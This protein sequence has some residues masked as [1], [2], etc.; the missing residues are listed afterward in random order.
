MLSQSQRK[1]L[2][3]ELCLSLQ[4]LRARTDLVRNI[5]PVKVVPRELQSS[6]EELISIL[7]VAD[8]SLAAKTN[9][10][11]L[12]CS[13]IVIKLR[14]KLCNE[15]SFNLED[16]LEIN[17]EIL[18][19]VEYLGQ[20][21]VAI[22]RLLSLKRSREKSFSSSKKFQPD[23]SDTAESAAVIRNT[24]QH[25]KSDVINNDVC[26]SKDMVSTTCKDGSFAQEQQA[27]ILRS[28]VTNQQK[29]IEEDEAVGE[30]D[31]PAKTDE[32]DSSKPQQVVF[33]SSQTSGGSA[34]F[35]PILF[36]PT[37]PSTPIQE[38]TTLMVVQADPPKL[39]QT[40]F[41]PTPPQIYAADTSWATHHSKAVAISSHTQ[42]DK[43]VI[44]SP[45]HTSLV[46]PHAIP[47]EER[48]NSNSLD[49]SDVRSTYKETNSCVDQ[50]YQAH[51][52][53]K[54]S[55]SN[56]VKENEVDPAHFN[57]TEVSKVTHERD[58]E[59]EEDDPVS[60][61]QEGNFGTTVQVTNNHIHNKVDF[62]ETEGVNGDKNLAGKTQ[63]RKSNY[64]TPKKPDVKIC[65]KKKKCTENIDSGRIRP[66]ST[67]LQGPMEGLIREYVAE[68]PC[69]RISEKSKVK[70]SRK[71]RF[72][73]PTENGD[74]EEVCKEAFMKLTGTYSDFI[75]SELKGKRNTMSINVNASQTKEEKQCHG[76]G[77]TSKP[78]STVP[79]KS[80]VVDLQVTE[81]AFPATN[82]ISKAEQ[83]ISIQ[84][85]TKTDTASIPEIEIQTKFQN[86]MQAATPLLTSQVDSSKLTQTLFFPTTTQTD[87]A[88][89]S[90]T[91]LSKEVVIPTHIQTDEAII[92]SPSHTP[93]VLPQAIP[94]ED[95][96]NSNSLDKS[97]VRSMYK[98]TN[99]SV[100]Q[101]YQDHQQE[102]SSYSNIVKEN[103]V[104]PAHFND[105][106]VSKVTHE[107]DT[108][109]E[110]D[111]PVS[112]DQEGN[113]G[114]T[115][116]VTNNHIHNKVDFTETEGVNGEKNLA[117]KTQNR[118]SSYGTPKKPDVKICCKKKKCT[119]N[120]DSGRIRPDS[121]KLQGPMEGLIREYVA[122]EPCTRISEKS[123]VKRSRKRRF[124]ISTENGDKEE[125]CKE[126]FMKLTGT[127]SDFIHSELKGKRNKMSI[128]VNASQTK[129]VK[130][131]HGDDKTSKPGSTVPQKS[132]VVE[133]QV[134]ERAVPAT[135][136]I[137]K[138][139]QEI[140]IQSETQTDT[141][142]IP[143]V[144]I[145]I[146]IQNDI[147]DTTQ[148]IF[149][150][151]L[152]QTA[153]RP[154]QDEIDIICQTKVVYLKEELTQNYVNKILQGI[155]KRT[156]LQEIY[157]AHQFLSNT[158][159]A[160]LIKQQCSLKRLAVVICYNGDAE[161]QNIDHIIKALAGNAGTVEKLDLSCCT[162]SKALV[163]E[164]LLEQRNLIVLDLKYC[165]MI[166]SL[167]KAVVDGINYTDG[168]LQILKL[169]GN[170]VGSTAGDVG[171]ALKNHP[172]LYKLCM[173]EC[174]MKP[175]HVKALC[176]G[177]SQMLPT[178]KEL[179]LSNNE[180]GPAAEDVNKTL[181]K[182]NLSKLFMSGCQMEPN[183]VKVLCETGLGKI[184]GTLKMLDLSNNNVGPTAEDISQALTNLPNLCDLRLSGCNMQPHHV[185]SLC[186]GEG[187][188]KLEGTLKS[189]N[190]SSN[191][192]TLVAGDV[193]QA[194][195]NHTLCKLCLS[196]CKMTIDDVESLCKNLIEMNQGTLEELDI[197]GNTVGPA[198]KRVSQAS[199]K[200]NKMRKLDMSGCEMKPDHVKALCEG[201]KEMPKLKEL[202]LSNNKVGEAAGDVSTAFINHKELK[203]QIS[204][205]AIQPND[206]R[207]LF[208][209]F[210]PMKGTLIEL[211]VSINYV[212]KAAGDISEI[213]HHKLR[214]LDMEY[215]GME[216]NDLKALDEGLGPLKETLVEL[217]LRGNGN[218]F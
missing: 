144:D 106:E 218:I 153:S 143:E 12:I 212:E 178:L 165:D 42:T 84:S 109:D 40:V 21:L 13:I 70:R 192:L 87:A 197:S 7:G 52:Q 28:Y 124:F 17:R 203:L 198:A 51:Q 33:I 171:Q 174:K 98:G 112:M 215:C 61:D 193:G 139:E 101:H 160:Q 200:H 114:T 68:K 50:H 137:S 59:D 60:M 182:H 140:S 108:E 125:V 100:D 35:S 88:D 173:K 39:A 99:S 9:E 63:N 150:P 155:E 47:A 49:K 92:S 217:N 91:L 86:N 48:K 23:L 83:E 159:V 26:I 57:D 179:N 81:L 32:A 5:I 8:E 141:A 31:T 58:T 76:D 15:H 148:E 16:N 128:N 136:D 46:L 183:N 129:E 186:T 85:E 2:E 152:S 207:A 55:Y 113:F 110:E 187:L 27:T 120:I 20:V 122:E 210:S 167:V 166:P 54:S 206:V 184:N 154:V 43:A 181:L 138:A 151:S 75:H 36:L 53:E 65:C 95:K 80:A 96:K 146:K 132:A 196:A 185:K 142:S 202:N 134:T 123:K 199:T 94:A 74:K 79:Q 133:L 29:R 111:D 72:F 69:T 172:N 11:R 73:I 103:E 211:D 56:I 14:D 78:G 102:E 116:Q 149:I 131:C 19:D 118:K 66:D 195:L 89:T 208:R 97:D 145:L 24:T 191:S 121:T 38:A 3:R 37:Y 170:N 177:L 168:K 6:L 216:S 169:Q 126:A 115:V 44:S 189:L 190:L 204:M 67:K 45:L 41:I 18:E 107:R 90:A 104:D 130:Q 158:L 22:K 194:L 180:I 71:R 213:N 4:K 147:L 64:G 161:L 135:N 127:Y 105:T 156:D 162:F 201:L 175:D 93:L 188:R 163:E 1:I 164:E 30:T 82:D 214:K 117:G 205:C 10:I 77:K 157:I 209:G 34:C 119:E 176:E 25:D 62:T